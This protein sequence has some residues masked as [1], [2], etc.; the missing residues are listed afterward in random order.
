M[1]MKIVLQNQT[2]NNIKT[3]T[4]YIDKSKVASKQ[5]KTDSEIQTLANIETKDIKQLNKQIYK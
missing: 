5:K 1:K 2:Y 3:F 4:S